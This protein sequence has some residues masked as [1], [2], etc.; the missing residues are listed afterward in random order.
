MISRRLYDQ[1]IQETGQT[2]K[3]LHEILPPQTTFEPIF[4]TTYFNV[5]GYELRSSFSR[6]FDPLLE[7]FMGEAAFS[8][9]ELFHLQRRIQFLTEVLFVAHLSETHALGLPV[10]INFSG[11]FLNDPRFMEYIQPLITNYRQVNILFLTIQ[12]DASVSMPLLNEWL[13]HSGEMKASHCLLKWCPADETMPHH[14]FYQAFSK[15]T[16]V[17]LLLGQVAD[18]ATLEK[19]VHFEIPYCTGTHFSPPLD[20]IT[21]LKPPPAAVHLQEVVNSNSSTF[22]TRPAPP[23]TVQVGSIAGKVPAV[24]LKSTGAEVKELF[25]VNPLTEG[26]VVLSDEGWAAG[27][28]MREQFYRNLSRQYGYEI[29]MN[30]PIGLIMVTHPLVVHDQTPIDEV[31]ELAM[32]RSQDHLYDY[33]IVQKEDRYHGVVS[34]RELL[35]RISEMN[36]SIA[37]YTNPLTG[38][39]G[40]ELI[41]RQLEQ[42]LHL[43]T[44]TLLYVDVDHFKAYNDI[45]GFEKGDRVLRS[46]GSIL[47]KNLLLLN[48]PHAFL[49]HIGGDDFVIILPHYH[50]ESLCQQVI[51]EFDSTIRQYY[52]AGDLARGFV[53]AQNRR[54]EKETFPLVSLSIAAVTNESS[55]F[56]SIDRLTLAA[57]LGKKRCKETTGSSFLSLTQEDW[58]QV[59]AAINGGDES[60]RQR[61]VLFMC[62]HNAARSQMAEAF[63]KH[64]GKDAYQVES[65][66]LEPGTL[67]PLVVEVMQEIDF[68][69]SGNSTNSVF[70]FFKEGRLYTH[71]ITVCDVHNSEKCPIFP[72]KVMRQNWSFPDPGAVEGT[73]EDKLA[74]VRLIRDQI[75]T[76]VLQFIEEDAAAI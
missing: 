30:R 42:A 72:G 47:Q 7:A 2:L 34:I 63:L 23:A 46:L 3:E 32:R 51:Q 8:A 14:S 48:E 66:G 68:D 28:I 45:Y 57:A 39:P 76:R 41:A 10:Y 17:P 4:S 31:G 22:S 52:H 71:V 55:D 16:G 56:G 65:A 12:V 1:V 62:V 29:F 74:Q 53:V 40:N 59:D 44:C 5:C 18:T 36:V 33:V 70:D 21:D 35:I 13:K 37:K 9:D 49:G 58:R 27:L 25:A 75:K 6:R 11:L 54:H 43:N 15:W 64:Y 38:L 61:K 50:Y 69:I 19:A 26:L 73:H 60:M 20:C 67:N 24:S